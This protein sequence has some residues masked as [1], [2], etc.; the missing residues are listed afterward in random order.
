MS[1]LRARSQRDKQLWHVMV[2]CA[3]SFDAE[4]SPTDVNSQR[5]EV[6]EVGQPDVVSLNDKLAAVLLQFQ[7]CCS[8]AET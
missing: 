2:R 7:D 4:V 3:P 1:D 6:K 5:A 8:I